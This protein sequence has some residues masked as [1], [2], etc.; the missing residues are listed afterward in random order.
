MFRE[1]MSAMENNAKIPTLSPG[2]ETWPGDRIRIVLVRPQGARNIGSVA[3]AMVN[4]GLSDLVLVSPQADPL[5]IDARAMARSAQEVLESA[6]VVDSLVEAVA[7]CLWVCGATARVGERRRPEFTSRDV[8]SQVLRNLP[9]A[10]VFG[11]EDTGLPGEDLDRCHAILTIPTSAK[12]PSLNLAQAVGVVAYEIWMAGL[13]RTNREAE[14]TRQSGGRGAASSDKSDKSESDKSD[15]SDRS[16]LSDQIDQIDQVDPVDRIDRVDRIDPDPSPL[17]T[18]GELE[19]ALAHL[20]ATL[21][22]VGFFRQTNPDHP[23]R[24]LRRFLA[25]SRPTRHELAMIRG[26]CRK[27]LNALRFGPPDPI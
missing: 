7:G 11:P 22:A 1:G 24:D 4:F 10:L 12:L 8:G 5:G 9:A 14:A 16:D 19:A 13:R 17:A 27:T 23:N 15:K 21:Q 20:H 25:R 6:R 18:A 3:R 2:S 26:M